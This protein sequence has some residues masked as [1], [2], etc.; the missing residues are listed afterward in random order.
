MYLISSLVGFLLSFYFHKIYSLSSEKKHMYFYMGFLLLSF[1]LLSL[2]LTNAFSYLTFRNCPKACVLGLLDSSFSLEDFSYFIY[3]GLS[4]A[5]YAMLMSAY[6][7][8]KFKIRR[9]PLTVALSYFLV[10]ALSLP[11][12][13]G[14]RIWYSYHEFF[15]LT[16]LLMVLFVTFKNAVNFLGDK[17]RKKDRNS[18]LVVAAFG[19]LSL[20]HLLHLFSFISSL[21]YVLA[22]VSMLMSF[23][24][25]LLMIHRVKK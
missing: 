1:G 22:H 2:S 24:S 16:A 7:P 3:F 5:A 21:M 18:L 23:V 4:I 8:E 6:K 17:K 12:L 20:F 14:F 10:V 9:L 15:H 11:M 25:L 19:F 13:E